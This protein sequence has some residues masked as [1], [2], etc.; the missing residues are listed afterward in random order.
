MIEG[1]RQL[2]ADDAVL[3]EQGIAMFAA[4]AR[5]YESTNDGNVRVVRPRSRRRGKRT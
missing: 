3:L 4:L 1:L 2:H 5:S